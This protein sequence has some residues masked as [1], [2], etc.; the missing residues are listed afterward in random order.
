MTPEIPLLRHDVA[1]LARSE[2][3]MVGT[4]GH[5]RA[6]SYLLGRMREVGLMPYAEGSYALP[7]R[8]GGVDFT[9]LLG[10]IPGRDASLPPLLLGAHY[11]T[12]GPYPGA[13]DNAAAVAILLALVP[14]LR[15]CGLE[16]TIIIAFF[17]A[18]EPP[19]FLSAAMGSTVY[20]TA[21]RREAIHGAIVLD[22]VGHDVPLPGLEDLLFVTGMESDPGWP[23]LV[24]QAAMAPGLRL[25]ASL[26]RYV[27]DLSDHHVFRLHERPYLFLTC[28]R[29][30]HYHQPSDTP[31]KLNYE[32]MAA[33][34]S[35]LF[36]LARQAAA[37]PLVGP[38]EGYDATPYEC[39]TIR[40][41]L[42]PAAPRFGFGSP[43][44]RQAIDRLAQRVL[45][46]GV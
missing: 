12:C 39:E 31:E 6:K 7:Y 4:P 35:L 8:Q 46:M 38:F 41:A 25:L 36:D 45:A 40:R 1:N 23:A 15:A 14:P 5:E 44:D 11:D 19:Y 9:N 42:G 13:D 26:N 22:L 29:W 21:Q 33:L 30:E 24:L 32:K 28:G 20:Y 2:G 16:R 3:R 37:T 43:C 18:E 17:D 10:R 34:A 27:G